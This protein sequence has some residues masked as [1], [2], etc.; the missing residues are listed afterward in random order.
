M[1]EIYPTMWRA[2]DPWGPEGAK[3]NGPKKSTI[4]IL[5][6]IFCFSFLNKQ[7]KK[8]KKHPKT[9]KNIYQNYNTIA[10]AQKISAEAPSY[11]P[12]PDGEA[13]RASAFSLMPLF[14]LTE[15]IIHREKKRG[16]CRG[17]DILI[18]PD[19]GVDFEVVSHE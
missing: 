11:Y 4:Y 6:S 16:N 9:S 8:K 1:H 7:F 19:F 12:T 17:E 15:K 13:P 5:Q 2:F 18:S 14:F 10:K 3:N